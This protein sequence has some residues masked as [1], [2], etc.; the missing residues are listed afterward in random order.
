MANNSNVS[1]TI[2]PYDSYPSSF[3][4]GKNA[5]IDANYGPWINT[6]AYETWL[7][8]TAGGTPKEGTLI[9]VQPTEHA[10]VTLYVYTSNVGEGTWKPVGSG[11]G[12]T[13]AD[14]IGYVDH[15][16][17]VDILEKKVVSTSANQNLTLEQQANARANIKAA[18]ADKVYLKTDVYTKSEIS[19]LLDDIESA[20]GSPGDSYYTK[21][22]TNSNFV[23]T[24][25]ADQ[26]IN[27]QKT[28]DGTVIFNNAPN[29]VQFN[30]DATINVKY[31]KSNADEVTVGGFL[32]RDTNNNVLSKTLEASDVVF[33][34]N[35]T[36]GLHSFTYNKNLKQCLTSLDTAVYN[37][38]QAQSQ[39][40]NAGTLTTTNTTSLST[41]TAEPLTGAVQLHKIS[42]TGSY[43][44]LLDKPITVSGTNDENASIAKNLTVGT[45]QSNKDLTVNG[46]TTITG[47]LSALDDKITAAL[48]EGQNPVAVLTVDGD[49]TTS[50]T[51]TQTL[52]VHNSITLGTATTLS[53]D[54]D[55]STTI[56]GSLTLADLTTNSVLKLDDN[57][58]VISDTGTYMKFRSEVDT[59]DD[60]P[61]SSGTIA[62]G[63]VF[64]V[65]DT[66]SQVVATEITSDKN[67]RVIYSTDVNVTLDTDS[68]GTTPILSTSDF[69]SAFS[70]DGAFDAYPTFAYTYHKIYYNGSNVGDLKIVPVR[71]S[72]YGI[73]IALVSVTASKAWAASTTYDGGERNVWYIEG[74]LSNGSGVVELDVTHSTIPSGRNIKEF[75]IFGGG[76]TWKS[77]GRK[78]TNMINMIPITEDTEYAEIESILLA[79]NIPYLYSMDSN[80]KYGNQYHFCG[81]YTANSIDYYT[82]ES[83]TYDNGSFKKVIK[84]CEEATDPTWTTK[85]VTLTIDA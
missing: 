11:S 60:L 57:K 80:C 36:S 64:Y 79:G 28:F 16:V 5:N 14:D 58:K 32:V 8:N 29:P 71:T 35:E 13:G 68:E 83:V 67:L 82:F 22:E 40:G 3:L 75:V 2:Y 26:T 38:S 48:S 17:D 78:T 10:D 1:D 85:T 77:I 84:I 53:Q 19:D 50:R 54:S 9:A 33:S 44:D 66:D 45:E 65:K 56:N 31:N 51:F 59:Y 81:G 43:S 47:E 6:N 4:V 7:F 70:T 49:V 62:V 63:D 12:G 61:N 74:M 39:S 24:G 34:K 20:G 55:S 15:N 72:E 46:D 18:D 73:I 42:K 21:T 37:L 25:S 27:G 76:V 69:F 41:D 30:Y 23:R 52:Q